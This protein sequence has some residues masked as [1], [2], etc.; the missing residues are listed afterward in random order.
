M[1]LTLSTLLALALSG[2]LLSG[3]DRPAGTGNQSSSSGAA[4]GGTTPE[5]KPAPSTAPKS[6]SGSPSTP[7]GGGG[8]K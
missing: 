6:P 1:K 8:T 7:S 3:C 2:A 5:K 4:S